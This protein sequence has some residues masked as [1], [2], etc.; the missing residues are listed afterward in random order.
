MFELVASVPCDTQEE[1]E[2]N[3]VAST[4]ED[5]VVAVLSELLYKSEVNDLHLCEFDVQVTSWNSA[6][7]SAR[8][9]PNR[10]VEPTGPPVKAVTYHD[11]LVAEAEGGWIG[12]V[13]FDV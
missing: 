4:V 7:V 10:E 8:G 2:I 1:V 9:V 3:A 11:I 6:V 12:R 5:L 13:Y